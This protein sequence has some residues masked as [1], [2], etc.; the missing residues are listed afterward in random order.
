ML[1]LAELFCCW[2]LQEG[3]SCA[4][5]RQLGEFIS[6]YVYYPFC[7]FVSSTPLWIGLTFAVI[8]PCENL[9]LTVDWD[10]SGDG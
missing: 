6:E 2:P 8:S 3:F 4:P 5:F 10:D 9:N 7:V 1:K